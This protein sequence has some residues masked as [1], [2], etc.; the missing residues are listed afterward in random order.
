MATTTTA[1]TVTRLSPALGA[2]ITGLDLADPLAPETVAALV[3]AWHQHIVL[4]FRDQTLGE[5]EQ[6]RFAARFGVRPAA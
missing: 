1:F 4:L 6:L 2:E 5:D 3:G